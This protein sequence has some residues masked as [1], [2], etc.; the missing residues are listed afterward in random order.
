MTCCEIYTSFC[1][2]LL[3]SFPR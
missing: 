3:D 1:Q 2:S